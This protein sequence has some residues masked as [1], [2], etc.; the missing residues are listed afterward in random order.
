MSHSGLCIYIYKPCT[1]IHSCITHVQVHT[2]P[3]IISVSGISVSKHG[4]VFT[5]TETETMI[6]RV[7]ERTDSG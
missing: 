3:K 6:T 4:P 7:F 1:L 2:N 5:P